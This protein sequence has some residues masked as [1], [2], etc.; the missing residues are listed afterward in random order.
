MTTTAT[1]GLTLLEVGQKEKEAT[2]N[3]NFSLLDAAVPRYLGDLSADP[4]ELGSI[5]VGSRYYNTTSSV[6]KTLRKKSP[7]T[8]TA[9]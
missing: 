3:T 4:S 1:F 5:P 7:V 6:F 9:E 2:I 8:W